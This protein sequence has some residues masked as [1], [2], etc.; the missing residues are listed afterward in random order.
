MIKYQPKYVAVRSKKK[1]IYTSILH[2]FP[3]IYYAII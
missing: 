3:A 2:V 1:P